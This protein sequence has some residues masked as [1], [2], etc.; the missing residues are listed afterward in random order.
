MLNVFCREGGNNNNK[1]IHWFIGP[2]LEEIPATP[3]ISSIK[4]DEVVWEDERNERY[5]VKSIYNL[6]MKCII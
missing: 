2:V 5:L 6:A 1:R 3:L 4:E